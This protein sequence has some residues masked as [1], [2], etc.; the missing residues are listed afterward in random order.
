VTIE[1]TTLDALI[2]AHGRP[3]FIKLDVEGYEYEALKG[4]FSRSPV[5]ASVPQFVESARCIASPPG[6]VP[7]V[8]L[9]SGGC[10]DLVRYAA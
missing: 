9:L 1:V 4:L 10:P 5:S 2:A 3:A 7:H 6:S 8:Q